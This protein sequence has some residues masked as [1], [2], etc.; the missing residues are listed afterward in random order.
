MQAK[1]H[2]HTYKRYDKELQKLREQVA[3]MGDHVSQQLNLLLNHLESADKESFEEIIENDVSINGM[4]VKASK[5]V[6]RLLA[7]RAPM[8]SDLR[9]I[10]ASSRTVTELE[11]IG[12]E[13]VSMAKTLMADGE[14]GVC[15]GASVAEALEALIASSMNLLDRALLASQND[16]ESSARALLDEDVRK[17]GHFH[18]QAEEL[19]KCVK[20]HYETT[21]HSFQ[22]ALLLNAL[23]RISSHISNIC[24]HIVFYITGEDIRHQDEINSD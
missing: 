16:D 23:T 24:E 12:D 20:E 8:G 10:I 4:E 22:A 11:R 21:Q 5:T 6:I 19:E 7:K 9:L 17:G 2:D 14:L 18:N 15:K 1:T 13:V 3:R